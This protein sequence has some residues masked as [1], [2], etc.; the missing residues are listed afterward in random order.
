[1]LGGALGHLTARLTRGEGFSGHVVDF[2][3]LQ[4]WPVFNLADAAIVAGAAALTVGSFLADKRNSPAAPEGPDR[5]P[6]DE[7]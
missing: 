3:D 6:I 2:I 5:A 4:V 1:V 7:R